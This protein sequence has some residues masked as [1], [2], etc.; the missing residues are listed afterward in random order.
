[1]A[2]LEEAKQLL[3]EAV[4]LPHTFPHLFTGRRQ[5][6]QRILLYGPPGTGLKP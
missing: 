4:F 3:R 6:W 2:G 5:P 1:V